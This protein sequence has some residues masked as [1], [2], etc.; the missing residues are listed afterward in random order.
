MFA[1]S[2]ILKNASNFPND[3]Q[4]YVI[5][6]THFQHDIRHLPHTFMHFQ[7]KSKNLKFDSFKIFTYQRD[8][9]V[10]SNLI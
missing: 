6:D 7:K 2:I 8:T 1:F 5:P 3:I 4:H 9:S 10:P